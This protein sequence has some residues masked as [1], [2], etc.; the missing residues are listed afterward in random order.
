MALLLLAIH[1]PKLACLHKAVWKG[2]QAFPTLISSTTTTRPPEEPRSWHVHRDY[3]QQCR[4][5]AS[6][7]IEIVIARLSCTDDNMVILAQHK[8]D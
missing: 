3:A 4:R 7:T 1:G 2:T 8:L 5:T 6:C